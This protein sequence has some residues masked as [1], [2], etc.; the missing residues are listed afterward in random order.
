MIFAG[1]MDYNSDLFKMHIGGEEIIKV[2]STRFLGILKD[3]KLSWKNH[4]SFVCMKVTKS[5]GIIRKISGL[6]NFSCLLTLYYSLIFP[7]LTYCNIVWASTF[8]TYLHKLLLLQKRF[9]R[10]ATFSKF[11]TPSAP[12]F[13]KCNILSI[14]DI[15]TFQSCI[16][17]FKSMYMSSDLPE[18]CK[19][20]FICNSQVHS[21][22]T[23]QS[24][25][26]YSPM[27]RT[28]RGQYSVKYHGALAWNKNLYLLS[29]SMSLSLY[30]MRL[31]STLIS[32]S[33]CIE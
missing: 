31:K 20:F 29:D 3:E 24:N 28:T 18:N 2:P 27:Y 1:K 8:P 13:L 23:R 25:N 32:K 10:V 9:V 33:F 15:N 6:L 21:Y 30:K 17:I 19:T 11:C 14:F 26:L 22:T 16:F 7:Y 4:I 12:L 5:L